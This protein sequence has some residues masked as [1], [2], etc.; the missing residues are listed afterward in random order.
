MTNDWASFETQGL[1]DRKKYIGGSDIASI[2]G[3][4]PYKTSY[5]LWL[6]KTGKVIPK[7]ISNMPHVRRG[8]DAEPTARFLVNEKLG[9]EFKAGKF[10]GDEPWMV[11]NVDGIDDKGLL[12]IKTMGLEKHLAVLAGQIPEYYTCQLEWYCAITGKETCI[13]ASYRPED[14]TLNMTTYW[15]NKEYQN[16]IVKS[17][18]AFWTHVTQKEPP[19]LDDKDHE[20][21]ME[22]DMLEA[23]ND[24][25]IISLEIKELESKQKMLRDILIS[26][27]VPLLVGG[28]K[29]T[30][31]FRKGNVEYAKIEALKGV[32]LDNYRKAATLVWKIS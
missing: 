1:G 10:K 13:F 16:T 24:Y 22:S 28:L 26:K 14:S 9:R 15:T 32:N 2:L 8:I 25:K 4:S 30:P 21:C 17:A 27:E 31:Y 12:E 3:I 5:Q 29:V 11:A 20:L 6:E 19:E 7:D 18:R 23:A